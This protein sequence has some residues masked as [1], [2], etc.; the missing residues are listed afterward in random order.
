MKVILEISELQT[1]HV[2]KPSNW[3]LC[4]ASSARILRTATSALQLSRC[5]QPCIYQFCIVCKSDKC[6]LKTVNCGPFFIRSCHVR[7]AQQRNLRIATVALQPAACNFRPATCDLQPSNCWLEP[8]TYLKNDEGKREK[9]R[10]EAEGHGMNEETMRFAVQTF[11]K[12][13]L[14]KTLTRNSLVGDFWHMAKVTPEARG[15]TNLSKVR[16]ES[17]RTW[18]GEIVWRFLTVNSATSRLRNN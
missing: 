11:E 13:K 14:Q 4:T 3:N 10:Q 9:R 16:D 2:N 17:S 8:S 5:N 6:T 15:N 12:I 7:I 18:I 1:A